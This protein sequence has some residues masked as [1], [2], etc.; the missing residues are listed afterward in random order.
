MQVH[1]TC[2]SVHTEEL[3]NIHSYIKLSRHGTEKALLG[4][5]IETITVAVLSERERD[6]FCVCIRTQL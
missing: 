3:S 6:R 1:V 4:K 2:L 5:E